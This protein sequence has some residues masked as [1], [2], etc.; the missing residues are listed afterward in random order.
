V[1]GKFLTVFKMFKFYVMLYL[2]KIFSQCFR[3]NEV[4]A[5]LS[6]IDFT[7]D[8]KETVHGELGVGRDFQINY[9]ESRLDAPVL[10]EY[11]FNDGP[12][13]KSENLGDADSN[14]FYHKIISIPID[15]DKVVIWFRHKRNDDEGS[16]YD[17]DYGRN[18]NLPINRP[19]IVFLKDW[20]E[21]QHGD[22]APGGNFD[23]FYDSKRLNEGS[24]VVAQ[25]KF[26]DDTVVKK[27]LQSD[28]SSYQTAVISI[29][30]NA[31]KLVMWF[32]Y[33]DSDGNKQYDSDYGKNYHFN[34]S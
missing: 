25:M 14:G 23:L 32:Y 15:A 27:T 20:Q 16:D 33:E 21:K 4:N 24:Q 29:P 13:F 3:E 34:L 10:V 9:A 30:D 19:S 5:P 28:D 8:W 22:L 12:D 11:K 6:S 26:L 7:A 2:R 31:E 1:E 18:Y 17:S